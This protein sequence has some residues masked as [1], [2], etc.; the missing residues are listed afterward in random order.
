MK[1]LARSMKMIR[2]RGGIV[3]KVEHWNHFARRR[4]DLFGM[5]DLIWLSMSAEYDDGQIV[6]V[7]VVNT[8]VAD[9]VEKLK[10]NPIMAYWLACGAGITIHSWKKRSRKGRKKWICEEI[11]L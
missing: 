11:D 1:A 8:H 2:D 9:H 5:F 10:A 6:G 3:A 7:Q 4:Q